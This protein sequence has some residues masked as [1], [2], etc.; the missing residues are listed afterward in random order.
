[1]ERWAANTLRTLGI[2]L[3][4]GFVLITS[5]FLLLMSI[6]A[7]QGGFSGSKHPEQV[8]PYLAAAALVLIL[9]VLVVVR[10][11]RGIYRSKLPAEA[12]PA[13][14]PTGLSEDDPAAGPPAPELVASH[15]HP[16][17]HSAVPLHLSPLGR[18]AVDRL[19]LALGAQIALSAIVWIFN[20]LHFWSAPRNLAP[21]SWTVRLLAP[22]ILYHVPY[23][24]LMYALVKKPSRMAFTYSIAVPAVLIL[25]SLFSLGVLSYYYVHGPVG[26]IL[27]V[28]PW[29]IH[30]VILIFAYRAI[31]QVG[32]HPQPSSLIT[33]AIVMFLYYSAIHVITSFLYRIWM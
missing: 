11:A 23:A 29:S 22:F 27:L 12:L 2:I 10:L 5:L 17:P 1:M 8:V 32:L 7:A 3:T 30:I 21:H 25:Q 13:G 16:D 9:G 20:Q 19:V 28:L 24:M 18:K 31:Q 6:C 4:S 26:V 15:P 14:L 33:A